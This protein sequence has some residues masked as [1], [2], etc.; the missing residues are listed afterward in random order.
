MA[1]TVTLSA[2][3]LVTQ[4]NS[5]QEIEGALDVASNVIIKRDN[6]IESRR[7]FKLYGNSLGGPADRAKQLFSYKGSLIRHYSNKLDFE[8]NGT[9]TQFAGNYLEPIAGIRIKSVEANSNFYFTTADGVKKLSVKTQDELQFAT[10]TDAG[11]PKALDLQT[12]I[13]TELGL[14]TGF[15]PQD[16]A[17]AYRIVWGSRDANNNLVL[18][19]PSQRAEI[20]N[21]LEPL[22]VQDFNNLL[23][24]I[25]KVT[26][27]S[28]TPLLNETNYTEELNIPYNT[29]GIDLKTAVQAL[30]TKL[31][32]DIYYANDSGTGVPLT[33]SAASI[34]GSV[35][36][37]T[38][39]VGDP[40]DYLENG[41]RIYLTGFTPVSGTVNGIRTVSNVTTTQLQFT[42]D[43]GVGA[44]TFATG[45]IES[46]EYR[47]ILANGSV[48]FPTALDDI[49]VS[50]PANNNQ[51]STIQDTLSRIID[52][53]K[54]EDS[55]ILD[56]TTRNALI[57][58]LQ[59]TSSSN[60]TLEF[61]IPDS[62]TTSNFYQVYR[63]SIVEA[64]GVVVLSDLTPNDELQ[65]V[66]EGFPT[67]QEI[68]DQY[69]VFT[70]ITPDAFRGAN[71]YTNAATGEGILQANDIPPAC[72]D[73][74][75]FKNYTFYANTR[76][77]HRYSLNVLG[78]QPLL[79]EVNAGRTPRITISDNN[80][81]TTYTFVIGVKEETN[82]TCIADSS[83]SLNGTYFTLNSANNERK[84]YFWYKTSGASVSD[85]AVANRTG[86]RID[87]PTNATASVV[88]EKTRDAINSIS[89]DFLSED[90]TLPTIKV[91]NNIEGPADNALP[92]T[93]GFT[94][95]VLVQGQGEDLSLDQVLLSNE[96]S[97]GIATDLTARSLVRVINRSSSS[98]YAYYLSGVN[99]IPG[100]I[101]LES[102]V[103]GTNN[104]P[105][106]VVANNKTVGSA[107]NPDISPF[108]QVDAGLSMLQDTPT[109]GRVAINVTGHGLETGDKIVLSG[110]QNASPSTNIDGMYVVT[111]ESAN[112]ISIQATIGGDLTVTANT[113]SVTYDGDAEVSDNEVRPNRI[114]YSKLQQP[115][116]VPL[117]NTIDLG[118]AD[119]A[120]LRIVPLR[121]SLFVFKEDG[122]FR[123]SGEIA[124]F[125]ASLFDVSC[126]L[127]AADSIG[128][129]NN[130]IYG[131]TRK[132]IETI[133]ESGVQTISRYI[134]IDILPKA[135]P[136]F[137]NFKT[138]TFG[139]GY[140]S[141]NAYVVW[142]VTEKN[143]VSATIA[144]RYSNLTNSWTTFDKSNTCAI[145]NP[146][147]DKMYLGAADTNFIEQERKNFDRTD[148]ADRE[149]AKVLPAN[150]ISDD[151][152]TFK[153]GNVS[154]FQVG[155][156]IVQSQTLT[157]YEYNAL[158]QKLDLDPGV[159]DSNYFNTL[160]A[161]AG[162]NLRSKLIQ[163]ANK[164]DADT[165]INFNDYTD[166]ITAGV[167]PYSGV[168]SS[169]AT[170]NPVVIT[171]AGNHGLQ[172][173]TSPDEGRWINIT[174]TATNA[175]IN[176]VKEVKYVS[177]TEFS[178]DRNVI[179]VTT[180]TGLFTRLEND[181]RDIKACYNIIIDR[182]NDDTGVTFTNYSRVDTVTDQ[183]VIIT[184]VNRVNNSVTVNLAL[185]F[186]TGDFT[187]YK[188][189]QTVVVMANQTFGDPLGLK[190]LREA[191]I[192]FENKAFTGATLSFSTDLLPQFIDVHFQSDG[193]GIFGHSQFFGSGFFGGGAN[194]A[195]FRTYIP[196]DCQRCRFLNMK[197]THA[198]AREKY[199]IFG[200]TVTGEFGQSTR[201]YR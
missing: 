173:I 158:L 110:T 143:D 20:Y 120:I 33:I 194:A 137:I 154:D 62:V 18:G 92:G 163:L 121:D 176:G 136:A 97:V 101:L 135:T 3:G 100:K 86:V 89:R 152:K 114:Y 80:V 49:I 77:R 187:L 183:E 153:L 191:T 159:G 144:Y 57:T 22:I 58:P 134:D 46:G 105:F 148:Y 41:D 109:L 2:I 138:A 166:R 146:T 192:M 113:I 125:S 160:K 40:S 103:L 149:F 32:E 185:D 88:A 82:I 99:D 68:L 164:L 115:E 36:T 178:V 72:S 188:K 126:I 76:T 9:F 141:D 147:D 155:D 118:A 67:D 104:N 29:S 5:L 66:Y 140:E 150:F 199:S 73:I 196:R 37:I 30:G 31:D 69:V 90:N 8:Y 28:S 130:A 14:S 131:W 34:T 108:S 201:G 70:D 200:F 35:C 107:F 133:T 15:L 83:N 119:K 189:I 127:S 169:I 24:Q 47:Y 74:N 52:R 182:L 93:S 181:F 7:G 65:L 50:E 165:G 195:P 186:V 94:I 175:P 142:T 4:P 71:L 197:F 17:V 10:I 128:I 179:D 55:T 44:V 123:V 116:A 27:A 132:G 13:S 184:N 157:I 25:D 193:N 60:V 180:G 156:V 87:I 85:P 129:V 38:F 111:R 139:I 16:S 43:A 26:S 198:T 84:Y 39:S 174:G 170:G 161:N 45:K 64:T 171:T 42:T 12:D 6:V 23:Y 61:T 54:E 11:G 168:I 167:G 48:D 91:T 96:P 177:P 78:I 151:K 122:L 98:V 19:T 145:I 1:S 21:P 95:A 124:P 63:S 81:S 112:Q 172:S 56:T 79:N 59:V 162:D 190:H 106:Y 117:V 75:T 51:L 102:K 53:L